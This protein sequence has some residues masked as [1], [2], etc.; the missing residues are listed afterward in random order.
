MY[1]ALHCNVALE[2]D[3]S[4][5]IVKRRF[6]CVFCLFLFPLSN[7]FILM[8]PFKEGGAYCF[9]HVR[10]SVHPSVGMSVSLSLVQLITQECFAPEASNLVG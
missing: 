9:A 1:L 3:T 5:S 4:V 7:A 2:M 6:T 10:W 8:H